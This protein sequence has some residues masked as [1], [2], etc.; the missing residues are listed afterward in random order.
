MPLL[1]LA[2]FA[3]LALLALGCT[4]PGTS[5]GTST[6]TA[7]GTATVDIPDRIH[8]AG[9]RIRDASGR[10]LVLRGAN[11]SND[12]KDPGTGF[13][14]W[15]TR[16]DMDKLRAWGFDSVR[17]LTFWEAIEPTEGQLDDAYLDALEDR[18]NRATDAGL[19]VIL[20]MHQDLWGRGFG[21]DGGA[22]WTCDAKLYDSFEPTDPWGLGYLSDQVWTCFDRFWASDDL[23]DHYVDAWA[24]VAERVADNPMVIGFDL[25]N[26]P[27]PAYGDADAF[28][29][30]PLQALYGR[31]AQS[32]TE[33]A[34]GKLIFIEPITLTQYG[35]LT[36]GFTPTDGM[37]LVYGPHY[38]DPAVHEGQPYDGDPSRLDAAFDAYDDHAS[39]LKSTWWLG[40]YG[41]GY[42][43]SGIADYL[44]DID[45]RLAARGVGSAIWTY[46]K[47]GGFAILDDKGL[48]RADVA[49]AL[50]HPRVAVYGGDPGGESWDADTQTL[51]F[52]VLTLQGVPTDSELWIGD[53]DPAALVVEGGSLAQGNQAGWVTIHTDAGSVGDTATVSVQV[54]SR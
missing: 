29:A 34:P 20:D 27:W 4:S 36:P 5:P 30:G 17:L 53:A 24:A 22:E 44:S 14:G 31:V 1:L 12:A 21:G 16:D 10:A 6:D 48:M 39:T 13:L 51:T 52:T 18:V 54:P 50:L 15:T 42:G 35:V 41:G 33:V 7:T 28:M 46:D 26:E 37:E 19:M 2:P 3:P 45:A 43:D 32:L 9:G 47:G 8:L 11:D 38:Y 40:E 23:Q 25:M 49:Q